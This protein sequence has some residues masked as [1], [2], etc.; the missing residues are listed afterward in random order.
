MLIDSP[1]STE[2]PV[3]RSVCTFSEMLVMYFVFARAGNDMAALAVTAANNRLKWRFQFFI[4]YLLRR[5]LP[6]ML[7][8]H[9]FSDFIIDV[10]V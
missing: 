3:S 8:S 1:S 5:G 10:C 2:S 7:F 9:F 6:L 4:G